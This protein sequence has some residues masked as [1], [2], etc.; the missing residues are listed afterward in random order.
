MS[1][2]VTNSNYKKYYKI[3]KHVFGD[4][5]GESKWKGIATSGNKDLIDRFLM[6]LTTNNP[7]NVYRM[8]EIEAIDEWES[9]TNLKLYIFHDESGYMI[10]PQ[11][12]LM[13]FMYETDI[14]YDV[15]EKYIM[16]FRKLLL[17]IDNVKDETVKKAIMYMNNLIIYVA[18]S[19]YSEKIY[20]P[21]NTNDTIDYI[22]VI[23]TSSF[24]NR[25]LEYL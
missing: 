22:K 21:L 8:E 16:A 24:M 3:Y 20:D 11:R 19:Y 15:K 17:L 6:F 14:V 2:G 1:G 25:L 23:S 18:K 10:L 9:D 7:K 5:F 13:D 4:L 12:T